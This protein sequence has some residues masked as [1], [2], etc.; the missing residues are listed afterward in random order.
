MMGKYSRVGAAIA[1]LACALLLVACGGGGGSSNDGPEDIPFVSG[2]GFNN[3][4][5]IV[6]SANDGSGDIYVGGN[7]TSYQSVT[8]NRIIRLDSTGTPN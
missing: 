5:F 6:A 1:W 7:F 8:P 4:V 3:I 2:T